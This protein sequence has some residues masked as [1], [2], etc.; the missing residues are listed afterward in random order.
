MPPGRL[1]APAGPPAGPAGSV[2]RAAGQHDRA[3]AVVELLR[4]VAQ[5][6]RT[7]ARPK[8]IRRSPRGAAAG[9]ASAPRSPPGG[10]TGPSP[11]RDGRPAPRPPPGP[12]S[13][14]RRDER[15][16][17]LPDRTGPMTATASALGWRNGLSR[18]SFR[19]GAGAPTPSPTT[20]SGPRRARPWNGASGAQTM[21]PRGHPLRQI[22]AAVLG[23][24]VLGG[25]LA[26]AEIL[27][28]HALVLCPLR[29][30]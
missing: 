6:A 30:D 29:A 10:S 25:S 21:V 19:P 16:P 12:G 5:G 3:R 22:R 24:S 18:P 8:E 11:A 27:N 7:C 28:Q 17:A 13:G 1:A 4:P 20:R 26:L 2:R 9:A 14:G 23:F 15:A